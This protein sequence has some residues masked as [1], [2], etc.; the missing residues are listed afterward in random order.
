MTLFAWCSLSLLAL[1]FLNSPLWDVPWSLK[2]P[3]YNSQTTWNS[4]RKTKVCLLWSF[5][6]EGTKYPR[7]EIQRQCVEQRLKERQSSD[8]TPV[9]SPNPDSI[10]NANNCLLTGAWYSG[11]LRALPVPDK[12][13]GGC[14]QQAIVLSTRFP[15]EEII[16][17]APGTNNNMNKLLPPRT[18]RD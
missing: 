6:E 2:Y 16:K 4:R 12:Y 8:S 17:K 7:K 14:S 1:E 15:M 10:V 11:L 13:R 5:F 9:E 3:R 18:P